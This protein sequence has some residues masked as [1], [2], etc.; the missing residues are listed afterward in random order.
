[1]VL[2]STRIAGACYPEKTAVA[3]KK[4]KADLGM[5]LDGDGDRLIMVDEMGQIV[6]GDHIL[7]I[8][9]LHAKEAGF[10][11]NNK[12]VITEMSN[13]GLEELLAKND[14]DIV[15]ANVG[16]RCVAEKMQDSNCYLGGE[17]LVILYS[18]KIF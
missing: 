11:K 4:H 15:K 14:I 9:A 13:L 18:Q 16:D 10:L 1:M 5:S 6:N 8:L 12:V 3:I 7:A 2:I 17:P